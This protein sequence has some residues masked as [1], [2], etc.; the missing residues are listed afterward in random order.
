MSVSV[1]FIS[2]HTS[3]V[4]LPFRYTHEDDVEGVDDA[5]NVAQNGQEDVDP[6]VCRTSALEEDTNWRHKDGKEDLDDCGEK[7]GQPG[8]RREGATPAC[9]CYALSLQVNAMAADVPLGG[10]SCPMEPNEDDG[11]D[12]VRSARCQS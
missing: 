6:E 4:G 5:G 1:V 11:S 12:D 9:I 3:S 8:S 10:C 7:G 2:M